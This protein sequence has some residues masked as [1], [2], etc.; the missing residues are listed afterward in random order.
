MFMPKNAKNAK[1]D[2]TFPPFAKKC[3]VI[4][5]RMYRPTLVFAKL[6]SHTLISQ[7]FLYISATVAK[8]Q[9]QIFLGSVLNLTN[10][11]NQLMSCLVKLK[12]ML[13]IFDIA[14]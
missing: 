3:I 12:R 9:N 11:W 8:M 6:F 5:V 10:R 4:F 13:T 2:R 7:T 1:T 14:T